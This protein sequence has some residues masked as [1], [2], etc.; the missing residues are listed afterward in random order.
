MTSQTLSSNV[1]CVDVVKMNE[2]IGANEETTSVA[3]IRFRNENIWLG[4]DSNR[5]TGKAANGAAQDFPNR[6]RKLLME[7]DESPIH[8]SCDKT[9]YPVEHL[10]HAQVSRVTTTANYYTA[11]CH[12]P[13]ES[14]ESDLMG[15]LDLRGFLGLDT[16]VQRRY[17]SFTVLKHITDDLSEVQNRDVMQLGCK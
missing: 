15:D 9:A 7:A 10:L 1:N 6:V 5:T 17:S 12:I 13:V 2:P 16:D 11:P 8:L 4:E 14:V 3:E